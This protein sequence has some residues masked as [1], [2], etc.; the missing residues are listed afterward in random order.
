MET[1]DPSP[2]SARPH[3]PAT[4]VA[5]VGRT[6]AQQAIETTE[7]E[8]AGIAK[9]LQRVEP[10]VT[11]VGLTPAGLPPS[12]EG[13][14]AV[15]Q[16]G[17]L[18]VA[19]ALALQQRALRT[20]SWGCVA[21][22]PELAGPLPDVALPLAGVGLAHKDIFM[23]ADHLPGCGA[24]GPP[25]G[26]VPQ[27]D[28]TVVQRLASA[29]APALAWLNMAAFACGATAENERDQPM[30]NPVDPEAAVGG[31]SS[32]SGVAVAA[33]LCYGA[34]GTDTAGSVR[35]PAATCGVIGLKTTF[36]L[37]P[38]Q[39]V[40]PLA[41]SL[42]TVGVLA[43]SSADLMAVLTGAMAPAQARTVAQD[44][45]LALRDGL[46]LS[47]SFTH[48]SPAGQLAPMVEA[49]LQ[50]LATEWEAQC[51]PTLAEMPAWQRLADILLYAQAADVHRRALHSPG[52]LP[53]QA[54]HLAVTGAAIPPAWHVHA[55]A[56]Q[57]VQREK[58]LHTALAQADV[59]LTPA[60][61]CGVPDA[62][63][64][65]TTSPDFQPR[66]LLALFSWMSFVNYLGLPAIVVPVGY[67]E[68]G[69]PIAVQAIARP[70]REGQLIAFARTVE[71][72]RPDAFSSMTS[73]K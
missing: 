13:L 2:A 8:C 51:M 11:T 63:L 38:G 4:G 60:L 22:V 15:L 48:A 30:S 71:Q 32:G 20:D 72:R 65:T 7:A 66:Q 37:L 68:R 24:G 46:R 44:Y 6:L 67:D 16:R 28:S 69:R 18:S 17:D 10:P 19:Q 45:D 14:R 55:L 49:T 12:I 70:G 26:W 21:R 61:P 39:G 34:L 43:R 54:R 35:M 27:G 23:W 36:G 9:F 52:S 33:G 64:V 5:E 40:V 59:L 3:S 31:S 56:Q 42:D 58:F 57:G 53:R 29:G 41:P 25:A 62:R 47:A 1:H 50:S 73:L